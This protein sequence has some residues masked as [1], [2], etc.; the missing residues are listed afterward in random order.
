MSYYAQ[1]YYGTWWLNTKIMANTERETVA[2]AEEAALKS[3]DYS[4]NLI[5]SIVQCSNGTQPIYPRTHHVK[6]VQHAAKD[7][8]L[9]ALEGIKSRCLEE[10]AMEKRYWDARKKLIDAT[11]EEIGDVGNDIL[12]EMTAVCAPEVISHGARVKIFKYPSRSE[13]DLPTG[14]TKGINVDLFQ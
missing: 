14:A 3:S 6:I 2:E 4:P 1:T 13:R 11:N 7:A 12:E 9:R 10:P 8:R 5:I